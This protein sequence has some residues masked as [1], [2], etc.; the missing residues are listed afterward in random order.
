MGKVMLS[1]AQQG[2]SAG[3]KVFVSLAQRG[4][5]DKSGI[6]TKPIEACCPCSPILEP[7]PDVLDYLTNVSAL[8]LQLQWAQ[9]G[10]G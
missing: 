5:L 4:T 6:F 3:L 10:E 7:N 1:L 9:R 8:Q 2:I